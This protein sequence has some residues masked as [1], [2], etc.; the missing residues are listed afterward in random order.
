MADT[1][2]HIKVSSQDKRQLQ[3]A[4]SDMGLTLSAFLLAAGRQAA[5][6]GK[7]T[8]RRPDP[9]WSAENQAHLEAAFARLHAGDGVVKT[10]AE[11]EAVADG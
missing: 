9:F 6:T 8:L 11:L 2:L 7:L 1:T 5:R 3:A 4:A 10:M